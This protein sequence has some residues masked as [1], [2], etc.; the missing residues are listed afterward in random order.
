MH[1]IYYSHLE[2]GQ[3]V[4]EEVFS[5]FAKGRLIG[6][7][8]K[9]IL[10]GKVF[11]LIPNLFTYKKHLDK[12]SFRTSFHMGQPDINRSHR[13]LR[14]WVDRE[15]LCTTLCIVYVPGD[16]GIWGSGNIVRGFRQINNRNHM[17]M[18][19]I[20]CMLLVVTGNQ[21]NGKHFGWADWKHHPPYRKQIILR[22]RPG[23]VQP[24]ITQTLI[25]SKKILYF[26]I[27]PTGV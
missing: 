16:V 7:R 20:S 23:R 25:A 8:G 17:H 18:V 15:C 27:W 3:M 14:I 21:K 5:S 19:R 9:V 4:I 13:E 2:S 11:V 10:E 26:C 6:I 24:H 12:P 1:Q 22:W